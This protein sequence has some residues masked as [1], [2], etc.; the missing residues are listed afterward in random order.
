MSQLPKTTIA[1]VMSTYNGERYVAE[2]VESIL[3]QE[4]VEV[5][6]IVRDDGS[7]DG[8]VRALRVYQAKGLLELVT[9]ENLG[10]TGSFLE[11]VRMAAERGYDYCALSDQDDVWH[12]DK[13]SRAVSCLSRHDQAEPLLYCS[14]Y[15]YCD[16]DLNETGRSHLCRIGFRLET[17]LYENMTSGNTIVINHELARRVAEAGLEDVYTHDWWLSLVA[18]A[19]GE[20]VYDDFSSLEYR[21]LDNNASPSGR[22][23]GAIV[24]NRIRRY[25]KGDELGK[26]TRQ[27]AKLNGA[28]GPELSDEHKAIVGRF[29]FGGRLDKAFAPMRLRQKPI[30][31]VLLR[32]LF[33]VGAL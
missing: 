8:T 12:P 2:Q 25:V 10:V 11:L 5:H 31:E 6:L 28:F 32:L 20:L 22:G 15:T 7:T 16:Q 18:S 21:R 9:G 19:I 29:L 33:L 17:M 4:D 30:D 13:L 14:E 26:V 24:A 27:I 23:M 3:G 1:V